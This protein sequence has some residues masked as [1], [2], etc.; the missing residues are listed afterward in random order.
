MSA[1][2]STELLAKMSQQWNEL[3]NVHQRTVSVAL[4][5]QADRQT[6][7]VALLLAIDAL[8]AV[9]DHCSIPPYVQTMVADTIAKCRAILERLPSHPP[10]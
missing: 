9:Q 4:Q 6:A 2:S 7:H 5:A 10:A 3:K 1:P 8:E